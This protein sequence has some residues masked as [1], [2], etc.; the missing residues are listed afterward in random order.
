MQTNK[1][2]SLVTPDRATEGARRARKVEV[3]KETFECLVLES[4]PSLIFGETFIEF[5]MSCVKS[6]G[7]DITIHSD[8]KPRVEI[9][10]I[11]YCATRNIWT[12]S[13]VN[14][15]L[16]DVYR[17]SNGP[18]EINSRHV[19]DFAY[20]INVVGGGKQRFRVNATGTHGRDGRGVEIT[21]R[22]LPSRIPDLTMIEGN[23]NKTMNMVQGESSENRKPA[24][25]TSEQVLNGIVGNNGSA[26]VEEIPDAA[27][28]AVISKLGKI[29]ADASMDEKLVSP[30]FMKI[31]DAM[32]PK[33]GL[34]I[35][36]GGVGS[37]KSTTLA[38]VI[39]SILENRYHPVKIVDIQAPIEFVFHDVP[40]ACGSSSIMG[41]SEVGVHIES[42]S[43]GVRS[44]LRRKPHIICVGEARDFETI[45][46]TLEAS[47][48]GHLVYTT[49]HANNISDTIRRL[50][51]TFPA[52]ERD[53]RG[54]DLISSLRFCMVQYL[55]TRIDEPGMVPVR[56]FI[57][58]TPRLKEKLLRMPLNDWPSVLGD[59]VVG[60]VD[61]TGPG[62]L[63]QSL[64]EASRPL[65]QQGV[66]SHND[67]LLLGGYAAVAGGQV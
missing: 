5:M 27:D 48:T 59:E 2:K 11:L 19:L 43:A 45:S 50:L 49:T 44:A 7:S 64:L 51:S 40:D 66:I 22:V 3:D 28:N 29:S 23:P 60:R 65:Y 18:A 8:Q 15:I 62:D 6:G 41:Q 34:V 54:L 58:F 13:D 14:Q 31:I 55:I 32:R 20:E 52:D 1:K 47:L 38:A 17:S 10:G 33:N 37:G 26:V 67:A 63:R 21:F 9:H 16:I 61:D 24:E 42:F 53:A 39:R 4:E 46:V 25:L 57:R 35:V 12:L 36:A 30:D 56:E